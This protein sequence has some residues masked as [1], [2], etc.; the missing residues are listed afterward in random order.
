MILSRKFVSNYIDLPK[1]LSI[2]QIAEDMTSV[3]NEYDSA[4]P[5]INC[6]NLITGE[7]IECVNHPDS[8]HLHV[9]KVNVGSEVL[10]IVCGAP[11]VRTGL[12]VIVALV[13]AKLPGGEIKSGMIRG[14]ES[15][16]ML[17]SKAELGLDNKFLEEKDKA[18][19][20]ELP[21]DAKIGEDPIKLLGLDDEVI[22]FELTS[23]RGDLLSILGMAY[24][25]G[26]IYKKEV[27]PIDLNYTSIKEDVNDE[28]KTSIETNDCSVFLAKKVKNV[29]I[30]ESPDFIKESLIASGIRPINNV[31][32]ISN[33][34]MLETGQPLHFYDAKKL[35]NTL[36]V[37]NA[38]EGET[39]VT[40]DNISRTLSKDDIVISNKDAAVGLA[41][42]MGGLST[43]VDN[44][45]TDIIIESAIFD[46]VKVRKTS[47]KILRSEASNRF[48]KGL[49]PKRT[50]MAI[51]RSCKLLEEYANGQVLSGVVKHDTTN[52]DDKKISLNLEKVDR[53]LGMHIPKEEVIDILKS[54]AFEIIDN[55][56]FLEVSVPSRRLDINIAEDLIE[57]IGRIYGIDN[58]VGKM[59]ELPLVI[60]HFDKTKREIKNKLVDLGLNET[61]SY[62]LI[63][64]TEVKKFTSEDINPIS[65]ADPMTEERN[66]LRYSLL[67]SLKEVYLYNKARNNSDIS[68]FEIG[69]G[70]Y[71]EDNSYK[72]DLKLAVLMTGDYYLDI[73]KTKVDFYIVKGILE[74]L[75]D[76]LGYRNRYSLVVNENI[77]KEFHPGASASIIM[78]GKEIG[79]I[80][81][82][83]PSVIKDDVYAFEINLTK[84]LLNK[85]ARIVYKDIPKY[86]VVK[87]DVAFI[88]KKD[89]T[90]ETVEKTIKK[91]GGKL[92]NSIELFDVYEGNNVLDTD[93]S[94]AYKL[95][96]LDETKTL[97]EEEVMN[98]FNNIIKNVTESIPATLR[99]N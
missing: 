42:V 44:D 78:Q 39:L 38:N 41:G 8:D 94:L 43:E 18:G 15:N 1:D 35:G 48:E 4:S 23:N 95:S 79:T 71:K 58:I 87:K 27:K 99:D 13:G 33:Y 86:P 45:T 72:E 89:V 29:G 7:V 81:K 80:G 40:L 12:K 82:L 92:L 31:V 28:F 21:L 10:Q 19:I 66:T 88:V 74:E 77:P 20:H 68:I 70:F 30:K 83:H 60:G 64:E 97:T 62:T 85:A 2:K 24:E 46:N 22:D 59:P 5:L 63:P 73:N 25:L 76:F 3:G 6:T 93:K 75:L 55:G 90:S 36:I 67:S 84:L 14:I 61:L 37:R 47:K 98:L 32:D 57:E 69:K 26:A 34:V 96:F 51:E 49:D 11:N 53:V 56:E 16:G 9:C 50:Y 54:L 65:L 17:C 91:A 52:V